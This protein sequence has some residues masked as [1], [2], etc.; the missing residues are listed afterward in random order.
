MS[1]KSRWVAGRLE[2]YDS[3]TG[4]TELPLAPVVFFEDFLGAYID[5]SSSITPWGSVQTN[6]NTAIGIVDDVANGVVAITLDSDSNAEMGVLHWADQT[7]LSLKQSLIFEARLCFHV[8]PL[9]GTE[10]VNSVF[11]LASDHNTTLDSVATRAWF[12]VISSA[13]TALFWETDDGNTATEDQAIASPVLVADTY[14]I[15]RIDCTDLLN[16]IKFYIDGTL[17]GTSPDML[18]NLTDGEAL[19]QPYFNMS[20]PFSSANTGTGTMYIDYVKCWMNRSK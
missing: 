1:T 13:Q 16:G 10:L 6:L 17:V 20:K 18:T 15:Y 11:G 9:T 19:V 3:K 2:F 5:L 8:L 12:G 14:H 4:Q 7:V